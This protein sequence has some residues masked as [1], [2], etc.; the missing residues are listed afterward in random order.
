MKK[1]IAFFDFDGTITN[2]DSLA[3]IIRFIHGD[4]RFF[5][6]VSLTAPLILGFTLGL[7]DRQRS[8]EALLKHFFGGM[9]E[10]QLKEYCTSFAQKIIPSIIRPGAI[11]KLQWHKEQEHEIVLVS[12]S[13]E[14]WLQDWCHSQQMHCLATKLEISNGVITGKI[15]GK[16]CH[17]EEKVNRIRQ[18]FDLALYETVFAYG[19]SEGDKPMLMLA[20]HPHYKPFR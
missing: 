16:N 19:D 11:E 10:Q 20:Q 7:Y 4:L 5:A 1:G 13:A 12:A 18:R 2:K 14:N 15:I 17:G 6:G 9:D 8:K 3:E